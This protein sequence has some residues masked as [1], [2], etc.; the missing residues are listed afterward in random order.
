MNNGRST[1]ELFSEIVSLVTNLF[2]TEVRL[3]QTEIGEK[4]SQAV[5]G[6]VLALVGGIL[7]LTAVF[8][9]LVA[10]VDFIVT[11]GLARYLAGL[12]VG[13]AVALIGVILVFTA[14]SKL[15]GKNLVPRRTLNQ[16]TLRS[17]PASAGASKVS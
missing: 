12:I 14:L 7:L 11:F 1:P 10:A 17:K 6:V 13:G 3:I 5:M 16:F 15:N 4:V 8:L 2:R 9:L